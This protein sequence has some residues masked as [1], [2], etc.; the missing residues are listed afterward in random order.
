MR[1][2][3]TLL[4]QFQWKNRKK[5]SDCKCRMSGCDL[6]CLLTICPFVDLTADIHLIVVSNV[7]ASMSICSMALSL[8]VFQ[9]QILLA[10]ICQ[11]GLPALWEGS[12]AHLLL[13]LEMFY[14]W[15]TSIL[16]LSLV[17][18][19][20]GSVSSFKFKRRHLKRI[21]LVSL[22]YLQQ[23]T[24]DNNHYYW[25]D[26]IS[27]N[28]TGGRVSLAIDS[29]I[30]K[31]QGAIA[32]YSKSIFLVVQSKAVARCVEEATDWNYF[33]GGVTIILIGWK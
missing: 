6:I 27:V 3:G 21:S 28:V 32:I 7:Q 18:L 25:F 23:L 12:S 11:L 13:I 4:W 20:D 19:W 17:F 16:L 8:S 9:M 1:K 14:S 26:W 31:L 22:V 2:A 15:L 5:G 30:L 10:G 24:L 33:I 29:A